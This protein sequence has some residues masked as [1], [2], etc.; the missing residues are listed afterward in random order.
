[1]KKTLCFVCIL[2]MLFVT[3]ASC[4]S[5]PAKKLYVYNWGEYISDG[6]DG[7]F[8]VNAEFEKK[9]GIEV[10]YDTYDNNEAM[11][12]KLKGGGVN[13]DI[14]IPSDYM[15]ERMI[16]E[17]MLEKI[18]FSN[19]PNYS[20]ISEKYLN[21]PYDPNNEYSVPYNVGMVGLIYN[22]K[23]VSPA[24]TSWEALWDANY[25]GKTLMFANP[26]DAFAIAQSILGIDYNTT[27]EADWN[28]AA[29]KLKAQK[30]I[31]PSY[32]N[33]EV[34]NK[35]ESGEA[36]LAPYYAGDFLSMVSVN[37]DLAFV[38]PSEGVNYF[39]DAACILKG[40]KNKESAVLYINFLLE[41][42]TALAN[43][44]YICYASPNTKV[45]NN[46]EYTYYQNEILYPTQ[47]KQPKTQIF[48][49]LPQPSL[50]LM[51]SLWDSV[52][53]E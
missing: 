53:S 23:Y 48:T 45:I 38:Y 4:S 12:A 34:F 3:L 44:E 49:N 11:Y 22:T 25:S 51:N 6:E 14:V 36:Y 9:Y 33:D 17:D 8:D 37:P 31:K 19:I 29:E 46:T 32:V 18:D 35:M 26:R 15:I 1:M 16:S 20:N 52:K 47:D 10:V 13:Y 41:E 27:A 43:A 2:S 5:E 42:E 30:S 40:S 50:D 39:V 7:S 21:Q 28:A 24:P